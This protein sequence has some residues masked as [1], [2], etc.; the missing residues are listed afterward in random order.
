VPA[1]RSRHAASLARLPVLKWRT[2][3]SD[4][5]H[6]QRVEEA[7]EAPRLGGSHGC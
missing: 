2:D 1:A 4:V 3:D 5:A 7:D 6:A